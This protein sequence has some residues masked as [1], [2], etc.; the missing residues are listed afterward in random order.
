MLLIGRKSRISIS[1]ISNTHLLLVMAGVNLRTIQALMGHKSINMTLRYADLAPEH[2]K[3]AVEVLDAL[4][5]HDNFHDT[6]LLRETK[7]QAFQSQ[8]ADN[9]RK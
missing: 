7:K 1:T 5:S 2:L 9:C 3:K 6:P 4:K 8:Y